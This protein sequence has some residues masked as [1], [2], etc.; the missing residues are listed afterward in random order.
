MFEQPGL[1]DSVLRFLS[2]WDQ[3]DRRYAPDKSYRNKL[4]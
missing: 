1:M 4:Y 3:T 2:N